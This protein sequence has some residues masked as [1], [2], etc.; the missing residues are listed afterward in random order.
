MGVAVAVSVSF[1]SLAFRSFS[2]REFLTAV[3]QFDGRWLVA[4][5]GLAM[6]GYAVRALRWQ[7][8][9]KPVRTMPLPF[10][11]QA[12]VLGYFVNVVL[13][14]N[15]GEVVRAYLVRR[16]YD[17]SM[18]TVL[19]SYAV[20]RIFGLI[21]FWLV[22]LVAALMLAVPPNILQ[23]RQR[24]LL[25]MVGGLVLLV[26]LAL[27]LNRL[28][29]N[30]RMLGRVG[31]MLGQRVPAHWQRQLA[32]GWQRFRQ[33]LQFGG[34]RGDAAL[35]L[36]YSVLLRVISALIMGCLARSFG[37]SLS[38]LAY[39]FADVIVTVAHIAGSHLLGIAGSFEISLAYLLDLFGASREMGLGVALLMRVTYGV[40][41]AVLGGIFFFTQG[42]NWADLQW[43]RRQATETPVE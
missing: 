9:L 30:D 11:F 21:A 34:T 18:F 4:G 43:L 32:D 2:W 37:I 17:V 22:G 10:L 35:I 14:V 3:G 8:I 38:L 16:E 42:L 19:G 40:P 39:I 26:V 20:E 6:I 15:L 25:G 7:A 23:L 29:Q 12:M 24:L 31:H 36:F 33:G 1:L 13:P 27:L 41:L 5:I 28:C